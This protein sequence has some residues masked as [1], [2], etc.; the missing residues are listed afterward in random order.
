MKVNEFAM[1]IGALVIVLAVCVPIMG[2]FA[3]QQTDTETV[4]RTN[5]TQYYAAKSAPATASITIAYDTETQI[6]AFTANGQ[7]YDVEFGGNTSFPLITSGIYG[8]KFGSSGDIRL[9]TNGAIVQNI[10]AVSIAEGVLSVTRGSTTTTYNLTDDVWYVAQSGSYGIY[11][12]ASGFYVN[13]SSQIVANNFVFQF[14]NASKSLRYYATGT[15]Q[16]MQ[17][18]AA[19]SSTTTSSATDVTSETTLDYVIAAESSGYLKVTGIHMTSQGIEKTIINGWFI[20]PVHYSAEVSTPNMMSTLVG[21]APV[22]LVVGLLM[23]VV[24]IMMRREDSIY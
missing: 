8:L 21:M 24:A 2:Q 12:A 13:K 15:A 18:G 19:Y 23:S 17:V 5:A 22:L 9:Y 7:Q 11:S 3:A 4:D 14:Y 16:Q 6:A 10:T 20:A 1:L